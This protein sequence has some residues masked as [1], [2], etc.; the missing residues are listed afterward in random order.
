VTI[1]WRVAPPHADNH[2]ILMLI[3]GAL[4]NGYEQLID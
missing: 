3:V 2:D 1:G 4:S